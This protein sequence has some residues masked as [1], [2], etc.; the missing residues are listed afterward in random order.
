MAAMDDAAFA[1][2]RR[3]SLATRSPVQRSSLVYASDRRGTAAAFR[4]DADRRPADSAMTI[5]VTAVCGR[6]EGG[7]LRHGHGARYAA[8]PGVQ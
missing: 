1:A 4:N 7:R 6:S 3:R 2:G 5:P 8:L